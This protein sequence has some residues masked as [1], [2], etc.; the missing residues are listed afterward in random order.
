M[1]ANSA[2]DLPDRDRDI[3]RGLADRKARIADAPD[4]RE[5]RESWYALDAGESHRPMILAEI[6]GVR[7]AVHWSDSVALECTSEWGRQIEHAFRAEFYQYETL[8][9]DHVIEPVWNVG[10]CVQCSDFGVQAVQHHTASDDVRFGAR[11]WDPPIADL[12][13]DFDKLHPRTYTVDRN[14]TQATLHRFEQLFGDILTVR[15]RRSFWWTLGMTQTA[16]NLIGLEG[17]MLAMFDNPGGLHRLMAFLRDDHAAYARWLEVEGLLTLNNENDYIGSGSMGYTRALPA[18][19]YDPDA[20]AR[21]RDLWVLSESQETVGVGPDQFGEFI[22]PYQKALSDLFGCTYYGCCEPVHNR[23][24]I[25][26]GMENLRRIS[27]SPWADEAFMAE[28]C[29]ND[30]IVYSRKPNPTLVSTGIFDEDAIRDDLRKTL[31][32]AEGCRLE[33]IMKDVHTLCDQPD[34]LPRWVALAR[35]TADEVRA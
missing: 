16:I 35:E 20:G 34:R 2:P 25:L 30:D 21:L 3:L 6:A 27:V 18:D 1:T 32:A 24:H 13:A 31:R 7:D 17:L 33:I 4:N 22:F 12:D 23:Y 14:A 5:R 10:W 11:R 8:A 19:G 26:R 15:I 9:D 29:R 28:A